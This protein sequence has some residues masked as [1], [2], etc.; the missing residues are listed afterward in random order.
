MGPGQS[1]RGIIGDC[2]RK[3]GNPG[4]VSDD[5]LEEHLN[6]LKKS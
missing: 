6:G 4:W 3:P 2:P 1:G 5:E